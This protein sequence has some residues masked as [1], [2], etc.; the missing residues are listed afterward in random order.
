VGALGCWV[1]LLARR[2]PLPRERA[3]YLQL[4]LLGTL[5]YGIP[6]TLLPLAQANLASGVA[7][8]INALTPLTTII[9]SQFWPGGERITWPKATGV[10]TGFIGAA[11]LA[12]P[13]L[14]YGGSSQ[15]WAIGA[16]LAATLCYATA[17][18]YTRQF[19]GLAPVTIAALALTG[20]ALVNVPLALLVHGTP[21]VTRFETVGAI[22]GIGLVATTFAFVAMYR[23]LRRIGATNFSSVTFVAPLSAVL[24]G[25]SLLGEELL[26]NQ[27]VGMGVIFMGLLLVD[28][29]LPRGLSQLVSAAVLKWRTEV[30]ST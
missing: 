11:V 8:I 18:N 17:L 12:F 10:V 13:A 19:A 22:L 23:L 26:P 5:S 16:C 9:V 27:C 1:F 15:L 14:A 28:G 21:E 25:T 4:I 3:V 7:A 2:Q 6:F 24:L 30:R 29:R 20:A